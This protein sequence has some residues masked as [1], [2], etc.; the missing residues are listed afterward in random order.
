MET[1]ND[2]FTQL[3]EGLLSYADNYFDSL[4]DIAEA[5]VEVDI[6]LN[7]AAFNVNRTHSITENENQM[8]KERSNLSTTL[9]QSLARMNSELGAIR[10]KAQAEKDAATSNLEHF[11][12]QLEQNNGCRK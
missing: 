12:S 3:G 6:A 9:S 10:T 7:D 4:T 8:A 5:Q 2:F 1:R 11:D